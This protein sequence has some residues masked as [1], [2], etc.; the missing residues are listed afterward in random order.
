MS[1]AA[2]K[3]MELDTVMEVINYAKNG[4]LYNEVP[5][6]EYQKRVIKG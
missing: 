2:R 5:E 3:R 1:S 4:M 6:Y